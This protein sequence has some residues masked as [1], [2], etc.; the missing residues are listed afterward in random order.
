MLASKSFT[1]S[2][3]TEAENI[4]A[5]TWRRTPRARHRPGRAPGEGAARR[6]REGVNPPNPHMRTTGSVGR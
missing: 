4:V 5:V 6:R 2:A 1:V 3:G